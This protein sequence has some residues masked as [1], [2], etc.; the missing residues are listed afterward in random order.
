M[1]FKTKVAMV[2]FMGDVEKY[3]C[4]FQHRVGDEV[5]FDGEK[6]VGRLCSS[7]WPLVMPIVFDVHV[8]GPRYMPS[9]YYFP[10]WYAP[11][12]IEDASL[13]K[14]DG[15]GFRNV[16]ETRVE[17]PYHMANLTPKNAYRWPP[18]SERTVA[19]DPVVVCKD[20][21]TAAVF[22]IEAID[23]ADRG[24]YVPHYR[25]QMV[26]LHKVL[27]NS[28]VAVNG[29]LSLFSKGES[30]GIYPAL[31]Q[32]FIE[33]LVEELE[34]MGHVKIKD[35]K[36]FVTEKGKAKLEGFKKSLTAEEKEALKL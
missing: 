12:S 33:A 29:L 25:R 21:R 16:L 5:I 15:L 22:K 7:V 23:V 14:Y 30:E 1:S 10:F 26:I 34:L 9:L 2:G 11:P 19:Q 35:G 3:P 13:R 18:H 28:D 8:A 20:L 17:P 24:Y 4:H 32:I 6:F 27:Q 31:S 36:I